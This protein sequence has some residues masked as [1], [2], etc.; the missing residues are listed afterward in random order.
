MTTFKLLLALL[1]CLQGSV[2]DAQPVA[3]TLSVLSKDGEVVDAVT[4]G[5]TLTLVVELP[6]PVAIGTTVR[7]EL[8][9]DTPVGRCFI[10]RE[11][12]GCSTTP[13]HA[14]GW[15]WTA[16][17]EPQPTRTLTAVTEAG[18]PFAQ[19]TLE[20]IPRPVVLVHGF[21]A[22]AATW[23]AYVGEGGFLE[24]S[25]TGYAATWQPERRGLHGIDLSARARTQDGLVL[26]RTVFLA[27]DLQ[28]AGA[29]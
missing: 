5:D 13:F 2:T 17:G 8:D 11:K 15:Y 10:S 21:N 27:L 7:F 18:V 6:S 23:Q 16:A 26:E 29:D 25:G 19:I 1:A 22:S 9:Q 4:D 3:G 28:R 14:L 20:I 12:R 24:P